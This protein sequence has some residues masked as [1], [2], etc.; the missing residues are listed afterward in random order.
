MEKIKTPR[1]K[2]IKQFQKIFNQYKIDNLRDYKEYEKDMI[3]KSVNLINKIKIVIRDRKS[4]TI[5]GDYDVDGIGATTQLTCMIKDLAIWYGDLDISKR[6]TYDIPSRE[7]GYGLNEKKLLHYLEKSDY[8]FTVDNGT[9]ENFFNKIK[10]NKEITDRVFLIDHH[11]NGDFSEVDYVL[12]PNQGEFEISTGY[13]LDYAYRV[14]LATHK[15]YA[16]ESPVDRYADLTTLT[17]ISDMANLNNK[18]VRSIIASGLNKIKQ[19][20]RYLYKELFKRVNPKVFYSDVAFKI[21]P[22]LNA[23]GRL[24]TRPAVAVKLLEFTDRTKTSREVYAAVDDMNNKRKE[25]LSTYSQKALSGISA[26]ISNNMKEY[27]NMI[28]YYDKSIPI[29][30]NG[31]VAQKI[32]ERTGIPTIVAS[33]NSLQNGVASG[34]GRGINMKE[35]MRSI[36]KG[37]EHVFSFGGHEK[38]LGCKIVDI[39]AFKKLVEKINSKDFG[40]QRD[41]VHVPGIHVEGLYTVEDYKKISEVL[42]YS[43]ENIPFQ[44]SFFVSLKECTLKI[45]KRYQNNFCTASIIDN[46]TSG[47]KINLLLKTSDVED[48][49]KIGGNIIIKLFEGCDFDRKGQN[50]TSDIIVD[51]TKIQVPANNKDIDKI[52]DVKIEEE[53]NVAIEDEIGMAR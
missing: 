25:I 28:F 32:F 16:K 39:E 31:L 12:N 48:Q 46:K 34:S 40:I 44:D 4:L 2:S 17:L 36:I 22:R 37:N 6:I 7:E 47:G 29:G 52:I 50:Y 1:K 13:L 23:V 3:K 26:H 43:C 11:P 45:Q 41:K 18:K 33:E 24:Y 14:L 20:E 38:A 9:H 21:N 19:K 8:V 51:R 15:D 53:N 30:L 27:K 49:Q 42:S 5:F 10:D 35:M